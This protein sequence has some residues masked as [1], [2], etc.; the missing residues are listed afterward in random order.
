MSLIEGG[1]ARVE[2]N[3]AFRTLPI[4]IPTLDIHTIGAGGGSIAWIND[5]GH[6]QV[7][8]QSASAVPGPACYGKGGTEAT[9][10]DAALAVGY[11]DPDN[12]LGGEI[13]LDSAAAETAIATLAASLRLSPEETASGILRI[14]EAKI[15][16]AVR[17][18]S[19]ER[20]YHP[21]DFAL[22]AFGGPAPWSPPG[23][24]ASWAFPGSSCRR[25]RPTSQRSAC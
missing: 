23:S 21:K 10:T 1:R 9:F 25:D 2:H 13:G 15:A 24:R 6:L 12:F 14:G 11:L 17:E 18:I 4:S 22:L 8:P 7:G 16:G 20:G 19:I 3:Q 5:G